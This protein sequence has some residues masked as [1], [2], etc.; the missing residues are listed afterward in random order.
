[1]YV[2]CHEIQKL[3]V[4][5]YAKGTKTGRMWKEEI[6]GQWPVDEYPRDVLHVLGDEKAEAWLTRSEGLEE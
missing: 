6:L 5:S 1:M 3:G 2:T 4:W